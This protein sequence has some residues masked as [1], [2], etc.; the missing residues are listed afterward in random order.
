[1]DGTLIP[2]H[3]CVDRRFMNSFDDWL[4]GGV[5][6]PGPWIGGPVGSYLQF[7]DGTQAVSEPADPN[8]AYGVCERPTES[9]GIQY[10]EGGACAGGATLETE[11]FIDFASGYAPNSRCVWNLQCPD[12]GLATLE[13]LDFNTA[14]GEDYT[15]VYDTAGVSRSEAGDDSVAELLLAMQSGNELSGTV[16][17]TGGDM[18][19]IFTSDLQTQEQGFTAHF[20]CTVVN[21]VDTDRDT[22]GAW[23]R[24]CDTIGSSCIDY[25][26]NDFIASDMCCQCAGGYYMDSIGMVGT[27]DRFAM[28]TE[29]ICPDEFAACGA[30]CGANGTPSQRVMDA[31][32]LGGVPAAQRDSPPGQFVQCVISAF[33]AM[34]RQDMCEG[35]GCSLCYDM[36]SDLCRTD[37][38]YQSADECTSRGLH[39]WCGE[40]AAA[41]PQSPGSASSRC[42]AG[43]SMSD[44]AEIDIVDYTENLDCSWTLTCSVG[45][46]SLTFDSFDTELNFDFVYVFEGD[47]TDGQALVWGLSGSGHAP[48]VYDSLVSN[49][50]YLRFT[51]DSSVSR[52]GFSAAFACAGTEVLSV[53]PPSTATY[54][55]TEGRRCDPV[56]DHTNAGLWNGQE[57]N[58]VDG[59][60]YTYGTSFE[61]CQAICGSDGDCLGFDFLTNA[62]TE[63]RLFWAPCMDAGLIE[64]PSWSHYEKEGA[65]QPG[66]PPPF[67]CSEASCETCLDT[68]KYLLDGGRRCDPIQDVELTTAADAGGS[69]T[70]GCE[71]STPQVY[72]YGVIDVQDYQNNMDC[73]WT[74]TCSSGTPQL[75]FD[76]FNT[77]A[78]FDFV[79]LY[80]G[81]DAS[82][83]PI[84]DLSGSSHA[85][86]TTGTG[87]QNSV[88][89]RF[90][91]DGSVVRPGF[92][93]TFQC[94]TGS[95]A[96]YAFGTSFEQCQAICDSDPSCLGIDHSGPDSSGHA[97]A[98]PE[99][100]LIAETCSS[101][102]LSG[103][104][105][106]YDINLNP[107][108][109]S[110][111]RYATQPLCEGY[112]DH[113]WCGSTCIDSDNGATGRF[114]STCAAIG[115]QTDRCQGYDD[116][117]FVAADMCCVCGGGLVNGL[118]RTDTVELTIMTDTGYGVPPC[119][120][121]RFET[122]GGAQ[123]VPTATVSITVVSWGSEIG[124]DINGGGVGVS[125]GTF[126]NYG[127]VDDVEVSVATDGVH[128]FSFEDSFGD[129][130]HGGYWEVKN[131]CGQTIA[132]GPQMGQ[133]QGYGGEATFHGADLCCLSVG[134]Q[135]TAAQCDGCL[136]TPSG[137]C[138]TPA[139]PLMSGGEAVQMTSEDECTSYQDMVWCQGV[140]M[141][142]GSTC[143]PCPL[144]TYQHMSGQSTCLVCGAGTY[145]EGVG[146]LSVDECLPCPVGYFDSDFDASTP[147][148][149]CPNGYYNDVEGSTTCTTACEVGTF[150]EP[151]SISIDN[152]TA[153]V[154][155]QYDH[156]AS[157][158]TSCV[159][160]AAGRYG[161][162]VGSLECEGECAVGTFAPPSSK[163]PSSCHACA[164]G[165]LDHDAD[166]S[167]DCV[168]CPQ[169]RF[170]A[171]VGA[172]TECSGDCGSNF[173]SPLGST[174]PDACIRSGCQDEWASNYDANATVEAGN[175][176]YSCAGL[177][178]RVEGLVDGCMIW[179]HVDEEN[180]CAVGWGAYQNLGSEFSPVVVT[181]PGSQRWIIQGRNPSLAPSQGACLQRRP[182]AP[183]PPPPP[184]EPEDQGPWDTVDSWYNQEFGGVDCMDLA[185]EGFCDSNFCSVVGPWPPIPP[186][187]DCPNVADL[188]QATCS[189]DSDSYAGACE[190]TPGFTG[191]FA[192]MGCSSYASGAP[193][194][195]SCEVD[196]VQ[197]DCP[198]AC[199]LC[200]PGSD[201]CNVGWHS[202]N[203]VGSELQTEGTVAMNGY[204][205]NER[206]MWEL[207][208]PTGGIVE[209]Q[210]EDFATEQ[211]FD[212]LYVYD[213]ASTMS[214]QLGV[215]H[216]YNAPA[217]VESSGD[218][219]LIEFVTDGSVTAPG[220]SGSFQCLQDACTSPAI[221]SEGAIIH[222][223]DS[224][225]V[226]DCTWEMTCETGVPHVE[227]SEL[228]TRQDETF[229]NMYDGETLLSQLHG[230][231][232]ASSQSWTGN[233]ARVQF[234]SPGDQ[235]ASQCAATRPVR[236]LSLLSLPLP[237]RLPLLP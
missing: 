227:V 18:T 50:L 4:T 23:G 185:T 43:N 115:S 192:G 177:T 196:G 184:P 134:A 137:E 101:Y 150:S 97:L 70:Y 21:C 3:V 37:V 122:S 188:C 229:L 155:G 206:C 162:T 19:V 81:I 59:E 235:A 211:N 31:F 222:H 105:N 169:G 136:W 14:E 152:C 212:F 225:G 27:P 25:N 91:T 125:P 107:E 42:T 82:G 9:Y 106:H 67:A 190:D 38:G 77:E 164:P 217:P 187:T 108:C 26:D 63:C 128:T 139:N 102:M 86:L 209:L 76:T 126:G 172:I 180:D 98:M 74:L 48:V 168:D 65:G 53:A 130:W 195:G 111:G 214:P 218:T 66:P 200:S 191:G 123:C 135:C 226:Q 234:V 203:P 220:F 33:Q 231:A 124:W 104:W 161:E 29:D 62:D 230:N 60:P 175:C 85:P 87:F 149:P 171:E 153:C 78:N 93:A 83:P 16:V 208:C 233:T 121:G 154:A 147:C 118:T 223:I 36:Q 79:R 11:G 100:H 95:S 158:N 167:S 6:T 73:S 88:Y 156:D 69:L 160:C 232:V 10:A 237:L 166:S 112:S 201:P 151:G 114:G 20:Q 163:R 144:G 183:P 133:V 197:D 193:N 213:G 236:H 116:A 198:I 92:S 174:S 28:V 205:N 110:G 173:Y 140:E 30:T 55:A 5:V 47:S 186:P 40:P 96:P 24:T 80:Q 120:A 219:M 2:V 56:Q 113:Q 202:P 146:A 228:N 119:A 35:V 131:A 64:A 7:P 57:R 84:V 129:G 141:T 49:S 39:M 1:M 22:T 103:Q 46:P 52:S 142:G 58:L 165:K 204:G 54:T 117:D 138:Y 89:L 157:A 143:S 45:S 210:F 216:G 75:S 182:P 99:C 176:E 132:G 181:I 145:T 34:Q 159:D 68:T 8:L 109:K 189:D 32:A 17:A 194:Y 127:S 170:S 51:S 72:D 215:F 90:T 12:G 207:S 178:S 41:V 94:N 71:A 44:F 224:F 13:I 221:V 179:K 61:E 15:Y 199:G 148:D